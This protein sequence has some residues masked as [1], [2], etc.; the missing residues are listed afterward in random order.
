MSAL[1]KLTK[2]IEHFENKTNP[3]AKHETRHMTK[4]EQEHY[5]KMMLHEGKKPSDIARMLG[6]T[7]RTIRRWKDSYEKTMEKDKNE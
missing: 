2:D 6:K 3:V 7:E 4:W 1:Q 5:A